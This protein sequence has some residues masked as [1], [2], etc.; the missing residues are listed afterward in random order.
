MIS[1]TIRYRDGSIDRLTMTAADAGLLCLY[2][3]ES[4][5]SITYEGGIDDFV[6][7]H[8]P[9]GPPAWAEGGRE[10]AEFN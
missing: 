8:V 4:A 10:F 3:P 6:L 1:V 7:S 2:P 5:A 9:L